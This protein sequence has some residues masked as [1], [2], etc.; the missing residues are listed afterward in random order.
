[1]LDPIAGQLALRQTR[2]L[3]HSARPDA[4]VRDDLAARTARPLRHRAAAILHRLADRL[5]PI[6]TVSAGTR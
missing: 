6:P 4:V 2:E 5:E 1:M 3:A